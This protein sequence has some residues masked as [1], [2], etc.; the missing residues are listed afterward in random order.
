[1]AF[2]IR[3]LTPN[4]PPD[5]FPD[6]AQAGVALGFPDGLV[7]IGGDLSPNRL[8]AAYRR[9]IFPWFNEDQPILWWSPDPR[10]VIF[11]DQFHMSRS[12]ARMVRQPDWAYSL[13]QAFGKVIR[14]CASNRG[15]Y[16][17]W[18]TPE[19]LAAYEAMHERGHAH[20]V[21]SWYQGELAGGIYGL[22]LGNVFFGESMYSA[23]TGGSKVAISGLIRVCLA[24]GLKMLDCQLASAHLKT[25]GMIELPRGEFLA[26]LGKDPKEPPTSDDWEFGQRAAAELQQLH[27]LTN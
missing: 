22:R 20:S 3:T 16:G 17:T 11:P 13:N 10:A 1:M 2:R 8:L 12:L 24:S 21:E 25:L 5:S 15:E 9:G 7:A 14:G 19:M 27:K 23:K 26:Q 18:I 6:P 4:D